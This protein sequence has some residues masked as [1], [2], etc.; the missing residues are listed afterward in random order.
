MFYIIGKNSD[1]GRIN[2]RSKLV[3]NL[4]SNDI[5]MKSN[6]HKCIKENTVFYNS[7][8]HIWFYGSVEKAKI[9][10]QKDTSAKYILILSDVPNKTDLISLCKNSIVLH[11]EHLYIVENE[12]SVLDKN[13]LKHYKYGESNIKPKFQIQ[14]NNPIQNQNTDVS[15][16]S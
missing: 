16:P 2:Q 8:K 7:N 3:Y 10:I 1:L 15:K 11:N 6:T 9:E 14:S 13:E 5:F 12:T 4:T